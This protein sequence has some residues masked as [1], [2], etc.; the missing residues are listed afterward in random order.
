VLRTTLP[1]VMSFMPQVSFSTAGQFTETATRVPILKVQL[2]VNRIPRL[3]MSRTLPEPE[4]FNPERH[5]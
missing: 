3:L 2:V 5:T 4:A 1:K